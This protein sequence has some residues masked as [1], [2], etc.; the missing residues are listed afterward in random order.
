MNRFP[1]LSHMRPFSKLLFLIIIVFTTFLAMVF[2]GYLV[3]I[4]FFG[5]D[6]FTQLTEA[7]YTDPSNLSLLKYFQIISQFGFF[8]LPPLIFA[9]LMN[10]NIKTYLLLNKAPDYITALLVGCL[11]FSSLPVI[12]W[13]IEMNERMMLPQ[14][15]KGLETWMQQSEKDAEVVTKIFLGTPSWTGLSVN[16]LMMVILPAIG[17]ELIF[18]GVLIRLLREWT[19]NI[20]WA[21]IISSLLFSAMH[22]QFYGFVPR[23]VLGLMLGYVF[24]WSANLWMAVIMHLL[25]NGFAVVAGFLAA[26]GI[27]HS[28][29]DEIGASPAFHEILLSLVFSVMFLWMI[30]M[31]QKKIR[32]S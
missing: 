15:L 1:L 27:I 32:F 7:N 9:Y 23:L 8:I 31:R 16:M 4:P 11:L 20:H 19:G 21:V 2:I 26:R 17:E 3:G 29:V 24:V 18:R 22:M 28:G 5:P 6:F 12:S 10:G 25:N 30:F 13:L 14:F